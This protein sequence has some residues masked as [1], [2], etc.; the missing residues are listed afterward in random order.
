MEGGHLFGRW[1]RYGSLTLFKCWLPLPA[2]ERFHSAHPKV[3]GICAQDVNSLTEP[4][5]DSE[6]VTV[7]QEDVEWSECEILGKQEDSAAM[8]M[9][10]DHERTIRADGRQNQPAQSSASGSSTKP[11]I[12]SSGK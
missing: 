4:E 12:G 1:R 11:Y 5:L 9:A 2:L 8:G 7:D 6:S 10:Y 3:V